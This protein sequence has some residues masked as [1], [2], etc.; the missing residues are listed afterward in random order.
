MATLTALRCLQ[1]S[2][3]REEAAY[4]LTLEAATA[5]DN[6]LVQSDVPVDVL[7]VDR[8]SAVVSFSDCDPEVKCTYASLGIAYRTLL[9]LT[10]ALPLQSRNKALVTFRCQLNTTRLDLRLRT[11]EGQA[12]ALRV[13]VTP[14]VAPK[15]A[16]LRVLRIAPLS[17]HARAH[18]ADPNRRVVQ[19]GA[20]RELRVTKITPWGGPKLSSPNQ[21]ARV[22]RGPSVRGPRRLESNHPSHAFPQ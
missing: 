11:V 5:I 4:L 22:R 7:D 14:L 19:R 18:E 15:C 21:C 16:A 6:V 9:D 10:M 12:G 8:N 3:I 2:L 1:M 13:Y 17:L 20:L